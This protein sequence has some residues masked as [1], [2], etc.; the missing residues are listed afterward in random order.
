MGTDVRCFFVPV[1]REDAPQ[2]LDA[3][4]SVVGDR[5]DRK[6]ET[7]LRTSVSR[8]GWHLASL[9]DAAAAKGSTALNFLKE[10]LALLDLRET[11]EALG[12]L[13]EVLADAAQ[14]LEALATTASEAASE[15]L[16]AISLDQDPA[17]LETRGL[18]RVAYREAAPSYSVEWTGDAGYGALDGYFAFL[19]SLAACLLE[20]LQRG[21]LLL[22]CKIG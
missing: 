17:E 20:S 13:A 9:T 5:Y 18:M 2:N 7:G 10:D 12:V 19:K 8:N 1:T 11:A 14:G 6:E 3:A 16:L 22:F 21:H 15:T 4:R